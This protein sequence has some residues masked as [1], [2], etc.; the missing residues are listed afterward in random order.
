[1]KEKSE[2]VP[3][4]YHC[5]I[6]GHIRPNFFKLRSLS[7]SKVR[8]SS[9]VPS[10]SKTTHVCHHCGVSGQIRPNCFKLYPH[11]QVTKWL[12]V[13]FQGSTHLFGELLWG[14][15]DGFFSS[16]NFCHSISITHHSSLI[17]LKYPTR[18]ALSLICH[19]SIFFNYLWDPHTDPMSVDFSL[20][21]FFFLLL[22]PL[23]LPF[24][25]LFVFPCFSLLF[26][27]SMLTHILIKPTMILIFMLFPDLQYNQMAIQ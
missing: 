12:Q 10:S 14:Y 5:H 8:P 22:F 20:S 13:P 18:L 1:M 9:R 16:L 7:T 17:T 24:V 19:H 4:C 6:V 2:F 21:L 27:S 3:I 11:K 26:S 25:F 15:L 23:P